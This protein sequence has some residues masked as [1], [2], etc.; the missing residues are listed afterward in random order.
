MRLAPVITIGARRLAFRATP[1]NHLSSGKGAGEPRDRPA[2][3]PPGRRSG[4]NGAMTW[5]PPRTADLEPYLRGDGVIETTAP[6]I[7]ELA[8]AL[9]GQDVGDLV[10]TRRAFTWVRDEVAHSYDAKDPRVTITAT[11]VL[12][13]RV[14]LCYAKSHLLTALLRS[15]GIATGLC[16]QRLSTEGGHVIHGLIAVHLDGRWRRLDPRGNNDRVSSS[17]DLEHERLAYSV[18]P[19]AGEVDYP[20]VRALA[21][22]EVIDALRGG[23]DVLSLPLPSE[24]AGTDRETLPLG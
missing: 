23:V 4:K 2:D 7:L 18:D 16:Y 11:E 24:L 19:E 21:A 6:E 1:G 15:R 13:E 8:S 17:F 20:E 5:T 10:F 22:A 12:G 3:W 9:G 14:G